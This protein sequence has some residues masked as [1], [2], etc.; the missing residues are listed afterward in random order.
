MTDR[1]P[2]RMRAHS[3]RAPRD[4]VY[5][6]LEEVRRQSSIRRCPFSRSFSFVDAC[7]QSAAAHLRL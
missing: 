5:K 4:E 2:L 6:S 1:L 7:G 3:L